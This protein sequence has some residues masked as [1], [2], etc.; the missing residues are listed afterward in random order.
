MT[1]KLR[2]YFVCFLSIHYAPGTDCRYNLNEVVSQI[3]PILQMERL[4][5]RKIRSRNERSRRGG[6]IQTQGLCL[7]KGHS[8]PMLLLLPSLQ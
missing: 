7:S 6:R 3:I 5:H 1:L 4:R 8:E 2:F